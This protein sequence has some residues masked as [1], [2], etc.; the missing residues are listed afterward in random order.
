MGK[1]THNTAKS[2]VHIHVV[3]FFKL[4]ICPVVRVFQIHRKEEIYLIDTKSPLQK[5]TVNKI[6]PWSSIRW[7]PTP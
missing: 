6:T 3:Y 4:V 5:A 1:N 2:K 7:K